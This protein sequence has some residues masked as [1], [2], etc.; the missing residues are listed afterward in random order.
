VADTDVSPAKRKLNLSIKEPVSSFCS[1]QNNHPEKLCDYD[2]LIKEDA[3]KYYGITGD[4]D[5]YGE[6]PICGNQSSKCCLP[7]K[8]SWKESFSKKKPNLFVC[9]YCIA[10]AHGIENNY[11]PPFFLCEK[12]HADVNLGTH[13]HLATIPTTR[14]R[15]RRCIESL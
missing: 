11:T 1:N 2:C 6:P 8:E 5:K 15:R 4:S 14:N 12:C 7:K 9:K 13:P 10:I 3:L